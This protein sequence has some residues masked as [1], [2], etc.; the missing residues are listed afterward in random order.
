MS[1]RDG[2]R[3]GPSKRNEGGRPERG[4]AVND[5][6]TRRRGDSS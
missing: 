1:G 6:N 5:R 3:W 4:Y 2:S